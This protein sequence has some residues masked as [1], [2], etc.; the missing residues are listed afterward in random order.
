MLQRQPGGE[1]LARASE[2]AL[3]AA[4]PE[5]ALFRG[6]RGGRPFSRNN[7]RCRFR[8]LREKLPHLK[9]VVAYCYRHTFATEALVNGVGVAQVAELLGHTSTEMVST[10]YGHLTE[11][12]AHLRE[13]ARKAVGGAA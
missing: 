4:H 10:H 1:R 9:G 8:R 5:G 12:V 13:A 7:V 3:A 2:L 6:P 11:K